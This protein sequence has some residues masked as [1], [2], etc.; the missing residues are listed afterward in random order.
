MRSIDWVDGAIEMID[1]T[2][3]PDD[4]VVLRIADVSHLLEAIRRL[5]IRGAPALGVA[6]AM[7][8]ALSCRQR[9]HRAEVDRDV[10]ALRSARPTAVSLARGVDRA[11]SR[12]EEG[13]AAVLAEALVIRDEEVAASWSMSALPAPTAPRP[14]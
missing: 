12:I 7:G 10:Q 14:A 3:L 2:R 11:A 8:V 4:L 9:Q 6:G 1:Q 13:A 5:A